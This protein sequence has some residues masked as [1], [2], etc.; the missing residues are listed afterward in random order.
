MCEDI[1][2]VSLSLECILFMLSPNKR[3]QKLAEMMYTALR[4]SRS[5]PLLSCLA[6]AS[7]EVLAVPVA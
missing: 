2:I 7:A 5:I 4:V 6:H 1:E 3:E